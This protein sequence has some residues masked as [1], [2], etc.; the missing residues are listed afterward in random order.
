MKMTGRQRMLAAARGEMPDRLPYAPRLGNWWIAN[1]MM[2]T[3]PE[4]YRNWP[5]ADILDDLRVD[6]YWMDGHFRN[7][8]V[9]QS[10][11][12]STDEYAIA[13][14]L[15]FYGL[16]R[17]GYQV[18]FTNIETRVSHEEN[19]TVIEYH[20]PVGSVS[21]KMITGNEL[22]KRGM[23]TPNPSEKVLKEVK[24]YEVVGHIFRNIKVYPDYVTLQELIDNMG[25]K[26]LAFAAG[27]IPASP[28][29]YVLHDLMDISQFYLEMYD[30]PKE[31][32]K[33]TEDIGLF[34]DAAMQILADS[35]A[36]AVW[37]GCNF[38]EMITYR[39]LFIEHILP[40]IQKYADWMHAKGKVIACHCDGENQKLLDLYIESGM[41]MADAIG[42]APM[43][44]S[45]I[46]ELKEAF[47][48]KLTILG[49]L[50]S[51]IFLEDTFS[52]EDFERYVAQ[53]FRE[54]VPGDR[55]I[56]AVSDS[57]P[58]GAKIERIARIQEMIEERGT[59]PLK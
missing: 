1:T 5:L 3:M 28:M 14:G 37:Y 34:M 51:V 18:E 2:D 59:L 57:T 52:D 53:L 36:E 32:Q 48:G 29:H 43:M 15:G 25:E 35:P 7:L 33:L 26:G 8:E 21:S 31:L 40:W 50:P 9:T 22:L 30:H 39:P 54:I 38:D 46:G 55:V 41:D 6:H 17:R 47:K 12:L 13:R 44:K 56:L 20:T 4:K 11:D 19:R 23:T 16:R 27:P 45:T 42:C 24:D 58:P 49:G 10:R